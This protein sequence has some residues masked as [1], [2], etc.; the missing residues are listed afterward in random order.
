MK[1]IVIFIILVFAISLSAI[2]SSVN[3]LAIPE[4]TLERP[5]LKYKN[6][7]SVMTENDFNQVLNTLSKIYSPVILARGGYPLLMKGDWHSSVVNAYATR[8]V[9]SWKVLVAGGIARSKGMTNDSL[10]LIVCHELGHHL[11]GAPRT[12]LFEGWPSAEGQ[13]DYWAASKCMKRYYA[14]LLSEEIVINQNIPEKVLA[15][16]TNTYSEPKEMKICVRTMMATMNFSTFLNALGTTRYITNILGK[17]NREVK[18][19]NTND[20]PRPQCRIDTLYQGALCTIEADIETSETDAKLGHCND[21]TKLGAR[22]R[23]WYRP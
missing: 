4:N 8:E 15:D 23:C 2:A 11:G 10:A 18:G 20:Y 22:P 5:V 6:L 13:A 9:N 7:E 19:T 17:D 1:K 16:C 21:T 12:F 3:P 14:E